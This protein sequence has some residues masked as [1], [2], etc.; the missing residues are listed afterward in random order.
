M[1]T[2]IEGISAR[3]DND[4]LIAEPPEFVPFFDPTVYL[5]AFSIPEILS[6]EFRSMQN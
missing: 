1:C 3:Q 6:V 2:K 4:P 5:P